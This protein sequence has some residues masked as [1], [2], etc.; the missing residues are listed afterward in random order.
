MFGKAGV[1]VAVFFNDLFLSHLERAQHLVIVLER[2]F[3]GEK[4][5]TC[6]YVLGVGCQQGAFCE[7][8]VVDGVE[9]IGFA[10][11]VL[12]KKAMNLAFEADRDLLVVPEIEEIELIEFQ[13]DKVTNNSVWKFLMNPPIFAL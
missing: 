6:P 11:A 10:A 3:D 1:V 2:A 4:I 13:C 7:R 9:E 12:P 8:Q 5:L